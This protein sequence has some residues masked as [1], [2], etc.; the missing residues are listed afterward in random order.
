M[1]LLREL[2]LFAK[3]SKCD[4]YKKKFHYLDHIISEE[5]ISVDLENIEAILNW[6]TPKNITNVISF[7]GLDVIK[8]SLKESPRLHT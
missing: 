5:E 4:F 3:I 8:G 6:P 7:M 1:Q 2:K